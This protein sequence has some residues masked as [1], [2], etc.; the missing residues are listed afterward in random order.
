MVHMVPPV[1][2]NS[3]LAFWKKFEF[4]QM[5]HRILLLF[6]RNRNLK[7]SELLI[8]LAW[9]IHENF[10]CVINCCLG[11]IVVQDFSPLHYHTI[12]EWKVFSSLRTSYMLLKR[13]GNCD[14]K[15]VNHFQEL[16]FIQLPM[17]KRSI[18]WQLNSINDQDEQ[19]KQDGN[20]SPLFLKRKLTKW[21]E[22][23]FFLGNLTGES[24]L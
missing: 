11:N 19:S 10:K 5:S 14:K 24:R 23:L 17:V 1:L 3:F 4:F 18:W 22:K 13:R 7:L 15:V 16:S 20:I 2:L 6:G 21:L 9:K 12:W 8:I